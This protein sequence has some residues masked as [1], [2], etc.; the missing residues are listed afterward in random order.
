MSQGTVPPNCL[1]NCIY[2][3]DDKPG[4]KYCFASGEQEVH[5]LDRE[6]ELTEGSGNALAG[7][8]ECPNPIFLSNHVCDN[9]G[10]Q[11]CTH[12]RAA[13]AAKKLCN[14]GKLHLPKTIFDEGGAPYTT[15]VYDNIGKY[16]CAIYAY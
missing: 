2:T 7:D 1:N 11:P 16:N 12:I 9:E 8:G 15:E 6:T 4:S 13:A 14:D 5:C 10:A 3:R